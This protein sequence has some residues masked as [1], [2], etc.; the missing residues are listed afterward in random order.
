MRK[1]SK[2]HEKPNETTSYINWNKY[3][4]SATER[5]PSKNVYTWLYCVVLCLLCYVVL[6]CVAACM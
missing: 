4:T 6:C 5:I 1:N 3:P 2:I